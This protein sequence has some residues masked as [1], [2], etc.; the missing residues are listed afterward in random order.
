[1]VGT[2]VG[3]KVWFSAEDEDGNAVVFANPESSGS[4]LEGLDTAVE[5]L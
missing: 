1:M 4:G 3:F 5:S 2:W